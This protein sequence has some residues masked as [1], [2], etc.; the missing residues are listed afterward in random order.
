MPLMDL[1]RL[2]AGSAVLLLFTACA[3]TPSRPQLSEFA[4]IPVAKGL[5]YDPSRSTIIESPTVKAARL[6][7]RGRIELESLV[8]LMRTT[9]EANGWKHLSST[10]AS[11]K[12]TTQV[13]EKSG[14]SLQVLI[15]ESWYYTWVEMSATRMVGQAAAQLK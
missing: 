10:T 5:S 2:L 9:L 7:Y 1:H 4:D 14:S 3:T 6:V 12:G 13:Y 15:Y 8:V 11:D